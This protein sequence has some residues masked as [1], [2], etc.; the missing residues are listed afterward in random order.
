MTQQPAPGTLADIEQTR[1]MAQFCQLISAA[2]GNDAIFTI[3][4]GKPVPAAQNPSGEDGL[5]IYTM[6]N[7]PDRGLMIG[8]M[9]AAILQ[10]SKGLKMRKLA[11]DDEEGSLQ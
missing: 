2:Y 11:L 10:M 4:V 9:K 1:L 3:T 8:L 5:A 6:A 7:V